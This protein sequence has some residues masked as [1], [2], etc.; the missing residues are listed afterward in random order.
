MGLHQTP[1]PQR[2]N[3]KQKSDTSRKISPLD[4]AK[5]SDKKNNARNEMNTQRSNFSPRKR[6]GFQNEGVSLNNFRLKTHYTVKM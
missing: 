1:F 5:R 4:R 6:N 2:K 3:D